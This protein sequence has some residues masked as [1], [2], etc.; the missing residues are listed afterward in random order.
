MVHCQGSTASQRSTQPALHVVSGP[1]D[2]PWSFKTDESVVKCSSET[3]ADIGRIE[4]TNY[5]RELLYK[6]R[7]TPVAQIAINKIR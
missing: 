3:P 7:L 6:P 5:E 1:S 2:C 4:R